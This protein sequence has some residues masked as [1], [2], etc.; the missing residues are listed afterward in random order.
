[1]H[2]NKYGPE[3]PYDLENTDLEIVTEKKDIG[4][5]I[6]YNLSFNQHIGTK[7]NKA[8]SMFAVKIRYL[9]YL[10]TDTPPHP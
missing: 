1:M 7:V 4:V 6:D 10:D 8:N 3:D 5:I 2:I 9:K